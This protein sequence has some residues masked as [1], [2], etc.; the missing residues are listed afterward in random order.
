MEEP[1]TKPTLHICCGVSAAV[2]LLGLMSGYGSLVTIGLA[3]S[4]LFITPDI[5]DFI[6]EQQTQVRK[7]QA[8]TLAQLDELTGKLRTRSASNDFRNEGSTPTVTSTTSSGST[9]RNTSVRR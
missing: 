4:A 1:P 7:R 8:E 5:V 9:R 6:R 3:A 2:A